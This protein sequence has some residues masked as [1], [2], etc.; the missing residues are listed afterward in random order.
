MTSS[1]HGT[2][3]PSERMSAA[4]NFIEGLV[5]GLH[6]CGDAIAN[7][8]ETLLQRQAL[9]REL[10]ALDDRQLRD[11]GIARDQIP[12][13][14]SAHPEATA[15]LTRMLERLGITDVEIDSN[16]DLRDTLKRT[17]AF[18]IVRQECKRFLRLP[19]RQDTDGYR[20]FCPNAAELDDLRA[21]SVF[22]TGKTVATPRAD[23]IVRKGGP[24]DPK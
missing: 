7:A 20:A 11:L 1:D 10:N 3:Q 5:D 23:P 18:C 12:L 17:C 19:N 15:L 14:V 6:S 16:I 2:D 9:E 13:L 22:R 4:K 8:T 24:T 21:A